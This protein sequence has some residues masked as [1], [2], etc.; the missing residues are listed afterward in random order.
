MNIIL[1]SRCV[2]GWIIGCCLLLGFIINK[3]DPFYSFGPSDKLSFIGIVIDTR[4]KYFC[5]VLYCFLNTIV[6]SAVHNIL[7]PWIILNIQDST[8]KVQVKHAH[9]IV[10]FN[11]VYTWF[12]WFI[13]INLLLAQI[14]MIIV[15]LLSELIITNLITFKYIR[16]KKYYE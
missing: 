1:T 8:N 7:H 13:Y 10:T 4:F 14:D 3:A 16:D 6:R 12:D 2:T 15:E 5:I 9:E 11:N